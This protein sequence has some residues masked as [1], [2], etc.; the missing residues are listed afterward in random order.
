MILWYRAFSMSKSFPYPA[1]MACIKECTSWFFNILSIRARSTLRIF[2]LIGRIA[3]TSGSRASFAELPAE[4]HS[5]MNISERLASFDEQSANL[6]G[7]PAPSN[8]DLRLVK[9]R[10]LRAAVRASEAVVAF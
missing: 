10:A 8:A 9:S 6:P 7:K 3:C 4:F 5:T 2:P 1:P